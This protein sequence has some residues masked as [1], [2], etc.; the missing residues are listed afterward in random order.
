[1]YDDLYHY[2]HRDTMSA[3]LYLN[4]RA[5]VHGNK[6]PFSKVGLKYLCSQLSV[7]YERE[8]DA[9]QDCRMTLDVYRKLTQQGLL[10]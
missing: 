6:V 1:M 9:L 4:D 7:S 2:H 10:G 5:A 3:A 8:H